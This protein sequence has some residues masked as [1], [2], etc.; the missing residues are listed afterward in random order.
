MRTRIAFV[1]FKN[2]RSAKD[3]SKRLHRSDVFGIGE[4]NRVEQSFY[5]SGVQNATK[6]EQYM[7]PYAERT[8]FRCNRLGHRAGECPEKIYFQDTKDRSE[9]IRRK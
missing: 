9:C 3:A 6:A 8:C 1:E 5:N 7:K 4:K 2:Y